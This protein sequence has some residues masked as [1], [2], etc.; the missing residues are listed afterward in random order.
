MPKYQYRCNTCGEE[1]EM[2]QSMMDDTLKIIE[3]STCSGEVSK[4]YSPA[5]ITFGSDGFYRTDNDK[6]RKN[7]KDW[8]GGKPE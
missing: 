6:S 2:N 1:F 4:V 7:D 5:G 3:H 8:S